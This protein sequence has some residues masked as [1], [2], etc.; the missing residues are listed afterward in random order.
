MPVLLLF[1]WVCLAS[2]SEAKTLWIW[3]GEHTTGK[4]GIER[5]VPDDK[6]STSKAGVPNPELYWPLPID[7]YFEDV[8]MEENADYSRRWR[9]TAPYPTLTL[10]R[11]LNYRQQTLDKGIYLVK[12]GA[13]Q[14][15]ALKTHLW[16]APL[17]PDK[18][19]RPYHTLKRRQLASQKPPPPS[20]GMLTLSLLQ[21]GRVKAVMPVIHIVPLD[22]H[23]RK[24][25]S[26]DTARIVY[27]MP[28]TDTAHISIRGKHY[29]Y[30]AVLPM[31]YLPEAQLTGHP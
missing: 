14:S 25:L 19:Y 10:S 1:L 28:H 18:A 11:Q 7:R 3:D 31:R 6:D 20:A 17:D 16:W 22:K 27:D 24:T 30:T 13:Y 4:S 5:H 21:Q 15:G 23:T 12:L 26:K 2:Q 8:D 9:H 29:M